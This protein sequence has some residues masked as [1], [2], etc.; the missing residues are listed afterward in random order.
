[1][2]GRL[3]AISSPGKGLS[4]TAP[5]S[6]IVPNVYNPQAP[7]VYNINGAHCEFCKKSGHHWTKCY[8][9]GK[10]LA[11]GE[12]VCPYVNNHANTNS[13]ARKPEIVQVATTGVD[14]SQFMA[15]EAILGQ[16]G[17]GETAG[18]GSE[19]LNTLKDLVN[20]MGGIGC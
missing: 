17:S 12:I 13:Q 16:F 7:T 6:S 20:T 3:A 2:P 8:S 14:I 9:L 10:K 15:K 1:M 4:Q 19:Q 5:A 11:H 18:S